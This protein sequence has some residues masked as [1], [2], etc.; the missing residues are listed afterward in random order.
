MEKGARRR[1]LARPGETCTDVDC[2]TSTK[3]S[4]AAAAIR[5]ESRRRPPVPGPSFAGCD[6]TRRTTGGRLPHT[7][8]TMKYTL[9]GAPG[10]TGL[11][12]ERSSSATPPTAALSRHFRRGRRPSTAVVQRLRAG[13]P[14]ERPRTGVRRAFGDDF[15][16]IPWKA[17]VEGRRP[18]AN[19]N[20]ARSGRG[21]MG[22]GQARVRAAGLHLR[23]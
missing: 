12:L 18:P 10:M 6:T 14:H 13:V 3:S 16:V 5:W 7:W 9:M 21:G 17:E 2:V 11:H 15:V 4:A 8:F 22:P 1:R 19:R 20:S 23:E